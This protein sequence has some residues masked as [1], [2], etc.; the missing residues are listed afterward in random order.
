MA[1]MLMLG[2]GGVGVL[3]SAIFRDVSPFPHL[4]R[5]RLLLVCSL[6]LRVSPVQVCC[7]LRLRE[8]W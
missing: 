8:A 7:S 5:N 1:L 2:G 3:R 6:V 4:F